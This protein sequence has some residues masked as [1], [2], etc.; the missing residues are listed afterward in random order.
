MDVSSRSARLIFEAVD[1]MGI[2]RHA[3]TEGLGVTPQALTEERSIT[4][5][6]FVA[7]VGRVSETV[8]HDPERLRDVGR[9][10]ARVPSFETLR[11]LA[12]DVVSLRT[13]LEICVYWL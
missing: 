13:L 12:G 5:S 2:S 6:Q 1:A 7:L 4:W 3:I 8:G 10:M 11:N 9:H